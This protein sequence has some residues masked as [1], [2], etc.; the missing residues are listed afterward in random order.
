MDNV[1][2]RLVLDID[3]LA[4]NKDISEAERVE[5]LSFIINKSQKLKEEV[6][7]TYIYKLQTLARPNMPVGS[8]PLRDV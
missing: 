8:N 5:Q 4:N 2:N 7:S 3:D 1:T 6:M